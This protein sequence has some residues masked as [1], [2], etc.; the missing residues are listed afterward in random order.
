MWLNISCLRVGAVRLALALVLALLVIPGYVVVPVLFANLDSRSL[1]GNLAG[2]IF[3]IDNRAILILLLAL[4]AFWWGKSAGYWR[5]GLLLLLALLVAL[6]EFGLRPEM[7]YLKQVMG[8]IDTVPA[9]DP[10]RESFA[11]WHGI[12]AVLHLLESLAAAILV[13]LGPLR[14]GEMKCRP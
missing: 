1:A 11:V 10:V 8:P 14:S 6:N 13:A 12:S 5:W 9:T 4:A 2:I 3:H 7:E